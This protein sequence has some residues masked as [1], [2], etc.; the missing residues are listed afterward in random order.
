MYSHFYIASL[1]PI[2]KLVLI[3]NLWSHVCSMYA[4]CNYVNHVHIQFLWWLCLAYKYRTI[5]FL[6]GE[7]FGEIV[8]IKNWW[9]IFWWMPIIA[10]VPKIIIIIMC[11]LF[12][13]HYNHGVLQW[14]VVIE[15]NVLSCTNK[16]LAS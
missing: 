16:Y 15:W 10:K 12:T 14:H 8:H 4:V 5:Q 7:N 3:S 9:I 1:N 13:G 2:T 11:L 6:E